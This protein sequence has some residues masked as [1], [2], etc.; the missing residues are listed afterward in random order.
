MTKN[1]LD[2]RSDPNWI[3]N[4]GPENGFK[5]LRGVDDLRTGLQGRQYGEQVLQGQCLDGQCAWTRPIA[6]DNFRRLPTSIF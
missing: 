5:D 1:L 2:I 3:H 4:T 6:V